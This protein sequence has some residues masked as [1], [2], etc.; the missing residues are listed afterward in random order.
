M[1]ARDWWLVS[2]ASRN[3]NNIHTLVRLCQSSKGIK[4]SSLTDWCVCICLLWRVMCTR[5][6]RLSYLFLDLHSWKGGACNG[7]KGGWEPWYDERDVWKRSRKWEIR[8]MWMEAMWIQRVHINGITLLPRRTVRH[9]QIH[10]SVSRASLWPYCPADTNK[11]ALSTTV[12]A[13]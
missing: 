2:S 1:I 4:T 11:A 6:R 3:G 9:L 10:G 7:G 13:H 5:S 8:K 12:R